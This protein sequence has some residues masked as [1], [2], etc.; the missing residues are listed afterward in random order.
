MDLRSPKPSRTFH[1]SYG[2]AGLNPDHRCNHGTPALSLH[3]FN[4]DGPTPEDIAFLIPLCIAPDLFG[5]ALGYIEATLGSD[6]ADEFLGRL[7]ATR[8]KAART[9]AARVAA[10]CEASFRTGGREHTCSGPAPH[11]P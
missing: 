7:T 4:T 1:V 6:L 9:L 5:A 3:L 10:C 2:G 11:T 8:S